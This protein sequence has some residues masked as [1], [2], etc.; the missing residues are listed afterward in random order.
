MTK[1]KMLI[2]AIFAA[3]L[4]F[5]AQSAQAHCDSLDGPVAKAVHKALETGNINPVLVY[6]PAAS[7]AVNTRLLKSRARC[8][9]SAPMHGRLRT[10]PSWRR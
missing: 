9:A 7:E 1:T 5:G 6:A 10:K 3:V 2:A 4:L 8:A